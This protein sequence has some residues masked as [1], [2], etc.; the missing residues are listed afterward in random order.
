MPVNVTEQLVTL[1]TVASEQL[2]A[3]RVPPVVPAVRTNV[4]VPVGAFAAV[5]VSATVATTVDVQLLPPNAM[6]H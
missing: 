4:T 3:L 5:V 2:V 6:L 1:E